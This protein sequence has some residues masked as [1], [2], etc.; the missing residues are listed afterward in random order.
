MFEKHDRH[1]ST[2]SI[3]QGIIK[4][5]KDESALELNLMKLKFIFIHIGASAILE[6]D[7][8][9]PHYH[10]GSETRVEV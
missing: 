1:R 6:V 4:F 9:N 8:N 3:E 2:P 10:L 7:K 5:V